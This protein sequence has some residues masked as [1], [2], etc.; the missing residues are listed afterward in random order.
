MAT[1]RLAAS[2]AKL[3][4]Q[5]NAIA[6]KRKKASDGWIG[7]SKHWP[8]GNKS[9]H[10]PWVKDGAMGIVTAIDV[11]SDKAN[12]CDGEKLVDDL[13]A[14]QDSRIKYII[15]NK[16]IWRSYDKP[17]VKAWKSGAY[18]GAN[19]HDKH[20]HIS[21]IDEKKLYDDQTDWSLPTLATTAGV[22]AFS[23]TKA[24]PETMKI[25]WGKKVSPAFKSKVI[26]IAQALGVDPNDLMAVM[27]FE[28]ARTFSPSIQH[29]YSKATGLIQ[30]MPKTAIGLGTT[31]AKLAAMSA[32]DQLDY[33]HAYLK[34]FQG[35]AKDIYDLYMC[36]LWPA[37]V[38][39]SKS[40]V[41]FAHPKSAYKMNKGLDTN[42]DLVVTKAEAANKVVSRLTEGMAAE[43][44]G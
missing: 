32:V 13:I 25:A 27:A 17:T 35:K 4:T 20:V 36:V 21:V 11:T 31:T 3:F 12:G 10:N 9:D 44:L 2:L 41:L 8:K 1:Y 18:A 22:M 42:D 7:D 16:K 19:L 28:S 29:P 38:G 43:W 24:E 23:G 5:V 30:F 39:K 15:H 33:V 6:P 37:A 14:S 34:P 40:H 26:Y